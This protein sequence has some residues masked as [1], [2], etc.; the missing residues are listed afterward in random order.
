ML[1]RVE[2]VQIPLPDDEVRRRAFEDKLGCVTQL[3]GSFWW[4]DMAEATE[5]YNQRDI[6]RIVTKLKKLIRTSVADGCA[7]GTDGCGAAE[8]RRLPH[9]QTAVRPSP[10]LLYAHAQGRYRAAAQ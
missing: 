2:L 9:H 6:N 1:D 4:S 3:E 5:G 7:D 8:K 10:G